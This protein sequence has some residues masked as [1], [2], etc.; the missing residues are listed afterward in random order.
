VGNAEKVGRNSKLVL[1]ALADA[2][3]LVSVGVHAAASGG[4]HRID[5]TEG[6]F[7]N[8]CMGLT[9][10]QAH[11]QNHTMLLVEDHTV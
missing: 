6:R 3:A 1:S 9:A 7:P 10:S 11:L 4:P 8:A 2:K 5:D